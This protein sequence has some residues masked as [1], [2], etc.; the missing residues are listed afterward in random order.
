MSVLA[1]GLQNGPG[2]R[3]SLGWD[4][5]NFL[6]LIFLRGMRSEM[7]YGAILLNVH[8]N[9]VQS[10]EGHYWTDRNTSGSMSLEERVEGIA[11]SHE[12][13]ENAFSER[14]VE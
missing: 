8:G 14:Q 1:L 13:A 4:E 11:D 2:R 5:R 7:H 12:I 6:S 3:A 9:P 10:L